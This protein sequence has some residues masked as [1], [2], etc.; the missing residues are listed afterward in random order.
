MALV[1]LLVIFWFS[2]TNKKAGSKDQYP[3]STQLNQ[4]LKRLDDLKKDIKETKDEIK[5]TKDE[6]KETKDEL[7]KD[8][9]ETKDEL[10]S[11]INMSVDILSHHYA[12]E[13]LKNCSGLIEIEPK[14]K[15]FIH[16]ELVIFIRI[17]Y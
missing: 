11:Q 14:S 17:V 4:I 15:Q 10:A 2:F 9:K 12:I 1:L 13:K 7:K 6:I 3:S 16:F 8:I 5:K